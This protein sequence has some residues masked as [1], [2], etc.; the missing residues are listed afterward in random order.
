MTNTQPK[1]TVLADP[2]ADL[3]DEM[4][5]LCEHWKKWRGKGHTAVGIRSALVSLSGE[6][7]RIN[8]YTSAEGCQILGGN[9]AN[10]LAAKDEAQ[11]QRQHFE[12]KISDAMAHINSHIPAKESKE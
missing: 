12:E 8:S 1:I 3:L 9:I 2:I 5:D 4:A 10:T 6:I 11:R 7:L